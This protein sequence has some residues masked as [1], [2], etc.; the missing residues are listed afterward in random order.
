M[1]RLA[2]VLPVGHSLAGREKVTLED[3][4]GERFI[5]HSCQSGGPHEETVKFLA[6]CREK[7]FTPEIAAETEYTSSMV[8]YV[9]GGRGVAVLNRL[10]IPSGVGSVAAVD[11]D[12][13]VVSHIYLFYPKKLSSP[14][15]KTF[16]HFITDKD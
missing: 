15:A 5:L 13:P 16:L 11:F 2:A 3:L 1:D 9:S 10:H 4:M 7:N 12:P 8:R 14:A 6:L